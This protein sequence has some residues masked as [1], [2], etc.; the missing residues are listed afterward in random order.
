MAVQAH[1][2]ERRLIDLAQE[3][4][5]SQIAA[6]LHGIYDDDDLACVLPRL[7]ADHQRPQPHLHDGVGPAAAR[8]AARRAGALRLLPGVRQPGRCAAGG[9]RP[10]RGAGSLALPGAGRAVGRRRPGGRGLGRHP[11]ALPDSLAL[12]RAVAGR[13]GAGR[14]EEPLPDLRRAGRV[15]LRRGLHRGADGHAHHRLP[16]QPRH[17]LRGQAGRSLAAHQHPARRGGRLADRPALSAPGGAGGLWPEPSRT[18]RPAWW[19]TAGAA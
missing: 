9:G 12:R 17:P 1:G 15:L 10:A 3:A 7:R 6:A 4:L 11:H 5:E 2:W 19:T 14:G 8:Q 16:G 18:S 13:R